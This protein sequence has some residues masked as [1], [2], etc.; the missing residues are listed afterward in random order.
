MMNKNSKKT[1]KEVFVY[2]HKTMFHY[3]E[4]FK[5]IK[6]YNTVKIFQ[7]YSNNIIC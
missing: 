2:I 4:F 1:K 6:I 7:D 5:K 3:T